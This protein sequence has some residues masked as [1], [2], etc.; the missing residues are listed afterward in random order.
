M[1]AIFLK[2]NFA[3]ISILEVM[4]LK[5]RTFHDLLLKIPHDFLER[6]FAIKKGKERLK[7]DRADYMISYTT[8]VY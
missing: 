3:C 4:F 8:N 1:H 6:N 7:L 5:Y 2:Q